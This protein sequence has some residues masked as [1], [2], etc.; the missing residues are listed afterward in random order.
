MCV[1][2]N[3]Y[4]RVPTFCVCLILNSCCCC[5]FLVFSFGYFTIVPSLQFLLVCRSI[6][7]VILAFFDTLHAPVVQYLFRCACNIPRL[8]A[9]SCCCFCCRSLVILFMAY[10]GVFCV[11][12]TICLALFVCCHGEIGSLDVHDS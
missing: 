6:R 1:L 9:S 8:M 10:L 11:S 12:P 2:T 4:V 5:F 7:S 3:I